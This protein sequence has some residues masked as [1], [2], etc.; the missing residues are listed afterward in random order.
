MS[1]ALRLGM[2]RSHSTVLSLPTLVAERER[3]RELSMD[4]GVCVLTSRVTGSGASTVGDGGLKRNE[5]L[6]RLL[7]SDL[8]S[9]SG[10]LPFI[11]G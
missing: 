8:I 9:A 2:K 5:A 7:R 11:D 10:R 3:E 4:G 6:L 1:M